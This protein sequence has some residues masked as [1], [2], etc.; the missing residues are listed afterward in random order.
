MYGKIEVIERSVIAEIFIE[1]KKITKK[2]GLESKV[3]MKKSRIKL[4][5]KI[6]TLTI[7]NNLNSK[8]VFFE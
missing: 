1:V 7:E 4:I 8:S 5:N 6:K 2:T 3:P